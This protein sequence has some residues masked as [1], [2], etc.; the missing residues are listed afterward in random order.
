MWKFLE[1]WRDRW[2]EK[3]ALKEFT[4]QYPIQILENISEEY[5]KQSGKPA[6]IEELAPIMLILLETAINQRS[7]VSHPIDKDEEFWVVVQVHSSQVQHGVLR[8][9]LVEI[10]RKQIHGRR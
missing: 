8:R 10:R 4:A 5:Y 6:P 3:T 7:V 9:D 2:V 1:R